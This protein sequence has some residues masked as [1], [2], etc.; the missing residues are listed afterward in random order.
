MGTHALR[1]L[2]GL[3]VR[4]LEVRRGELASVREQ[5]LAGFVRRRELRRLRIDRFHTVD[6]LTAW[7]TLGQEFPWLFVTGTLG[8]PC[9]RMHAVYATASA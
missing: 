6:G 2:Q 8:T 3:R 7:P 5:M 1:V 4:L 9:L